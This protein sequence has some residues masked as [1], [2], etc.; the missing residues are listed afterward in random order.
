MIILQTWELTRVH[1]HQLIEGAKICAIQ[2]GAPDVHLIC[3]KVR[4]QEGGVENVLLSQMLT[5]KEM[6][7]PTHGCQLL[8]RVEILPGM[9]G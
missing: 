6:L 2:V 5:E 4:L 3:A 7:M 9:P 1:A 8:S